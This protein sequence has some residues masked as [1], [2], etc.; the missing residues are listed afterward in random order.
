MYQPD[1][2]MKPNRVPILN[3][4]KID[5]IGERLIQE[6]QPG[7]LH[8][9]EEIDIDGFV[10]FY[11]N[12][13]TD[14]QYLS[15]NGVYLGMTV[16]NDS[17]VP[18]YDPETERAEYVKEKAGTVIIDNRLLED[19]QEHRYRFTMAHE[20]SHCVLH[21]QYFEALMERMSNKDVSLAPLVVCRTVNRDLQNRRPD[22]WTDYDS[23]E[24]QANY[25][26]GALLMPEKM[27][28]LLAAPH[29]SRMDDVKETRSFIKDLC[30]IFNVSYE[31]AC[32]RLMQLG[33]FDNRMAEE[34][35]RKNVSEYTPV[36]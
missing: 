10:E 12:R 7:A 32:I 21:K 1:F 18:V 36:K 6:Y 30:A 19:D 17:L 27:V 11:L 3:K 34:L 15:H 29:T 20:G 22:E 9:A 26:G 14:Y 31:T 4:K 8:H 33:Y 24:W 28:R 23:M 5:S 2:W 35:H 13:D 25:L 16:F